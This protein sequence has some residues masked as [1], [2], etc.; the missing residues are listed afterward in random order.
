MVIG[1]KPGYIGN[2]ASSPLVTIS[3]VNT[4]VTVP[5]TVPPYSVSGTVTDVVSGATVPG[6]QVFAT[7]TNNEYTAFF[8]DADGNFTFAASTGQWKLDPSDYALML[9]GFVRSGNKVKVSVPAANVNGVMV[10]LTKGTALIYGAVQDDLS[11]PLPGVR[12]NGGDNGNLFQ[13]TTYSDG[14]GNYFMAVSNA[15][16]Y[17]GP[18]NNNVGLP[19][20]YTLQSV[21]VAIANG[22]AVQTNLIAHRAT[23]HL[24]G[25]A[26]NG[27]SNPIAGGS[28]LAFGTNG[29]TVSAQT[30]GDGSF[31]LPVSGGP[32]SISLDTQTASSQGLVAPQLS[33]TVTD[34]VNISNITYVA[35]L[36]NRT[37]SG[38]VKTGNKA[39]I[40]GISVFANCVINGTNYQSG[41]NTD[42]GGNYSMPAIPGLWSVGV[43]SQALTQQG[44]GI[45]FNQ[46][47]DT[48]SSNQVVNFVVGTPPVGFMF[49]RHTLGVVGEFGSSRTPT[50][51][52]PVSIHN[53]RVLFHVYNETNPPAA[54]TVFFTGP[55]GSGL[56]NSPAD[57]SLGAVQS[58]PD[59]VYFSLQT[60][61]PSI[62]M[63]GNWSIN[64]RSNANNFVVPDPQAQTRV[65]VPLPT[66]TISNGFLRSLTWT[67]KDQ[68]GNP[69]T[70]TP[71]FVQNDRID[72]ID[73]NGNLFDTEVIPPTTSYAY[74]ATNLYSWLDVG[75]LRMN[76]YD[77]LTNQYFVAFS[78]SS[79]TLTGVSRLSG[80]RFQ[81]LLNGPAGQNYTIQFST[82]LASTNWNALFV[83]NN[84]TSP[85]TIIDPAATNSRRFYRVLVGP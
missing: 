85:I 65:L 1:F 18:D 24:I 27:N 64:Y 55:P 12:L 4:N 70:G 60:K 82:N 59:V 68:N 75:I 37:I 9:G 83:T 11:N 69:I 44:Y 43:D 19:S 31:D 78:E 34:G 72:L 52:Y 51:T 53:Y 8:S 71:G 15:T 23:A 67:Y 22:Q 45:V 61:N 49:F 17:V 25:H 36:G 13:S 16:W 39:P 20:G 40:T 76:Y 73:Q 28:M 58:G 29:A 54:S 62:A 3:G 63:G 41:A 26:L 30:A 35:P 50:V 79:P 5:L 38:W 47:A 6:I 77:D 81:F 21:Q 80:Q 46:N 7:S 57:S 56:T 66:V 42:S 48:S 14:S 33:F 32:W 2:F 10:P 84:L 74:A